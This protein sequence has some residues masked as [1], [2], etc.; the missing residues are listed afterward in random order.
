M[1]AILPCDNSLFDVFQQAAVALVNGYECR[2]EQLDEITWSRHDTAQGILKPLITNTD[3][4]EAHASKI[5]NLHTHTHTVSTAQ[6]YCSSCSIWTEWQSKNNHKML[7]V[8]KMNQG[9]CS[10]LLGKTVLKCHQKHLN[11]SDKQ[12]KD[13]WI[14]WLNNKKSMASQSAK[15]ALLDFIRDPTNSRDCSRHLLKT[16]MFAWY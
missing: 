16:Y 14:S 7:L 13:N 12:Q 9:C 4:H 6:T 11:E 1:E 8:T 3:I 15:A 2:K 5:S 10:L